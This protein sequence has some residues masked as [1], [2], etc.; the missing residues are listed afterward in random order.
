V[1][2]SASRR[3]DIPAAYAD[4]FFRRLQEGFVLVRNP[5]NPRQVSRI[6]L[7]PEAVDG[8][9]FWTKNPVPMLDRL[10]LLREYAYYF[11]CTLTPYGAEIEPN[12]PSKG[13]VMLPAIRRLSDEI[14]PDRVIWRYDPIFLSG[15]YTVEAHLLAFERMAKYLR[16]YTRRCTVSFMDDYRNTRSQMASAGARETT[17]E[18]REQICRAFSAIARAEGMAPEACAEPH[19]LSGFG[20]G[21]ARCVDARI[22]ESQLGRPL[23]ARKDPNQRPECGCAQSAD[24][25]AYNTCPNGCR[26]CYA[27]YSP[28]LMAMNRARH[29]PLSPFLIGEPQEGDVIR[30]RGTRLPKGVQTSFGEPPL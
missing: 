6:P 22:L 14:G 8:F 12:I 9:V 15:Q 1:I 10:D 3:T 13:D 16:G 11:Q 28:K 18:E 30:E 23:P 25:G 5:R 21:R 29:N 24:I 19:D 4:W 7:A 2:V 17:P 20:I 26:Y 27:N